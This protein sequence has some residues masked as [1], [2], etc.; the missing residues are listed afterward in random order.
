MGV[1]ANGA[2]NFADS[3][4]AIETITVAEPGFE[5]VTSGTNQI[6]ENH[7]FVELSYPP[8]Q[9]LSVRPR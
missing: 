3:H 9:E 6:E 7:R 8:A 4:Q 1:T 5:S 2:L